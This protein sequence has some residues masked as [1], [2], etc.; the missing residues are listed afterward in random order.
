MIEIDKTQYHKL[1]DDLKDIETVPI[2]ALAIIDNFIEGVVLTD[3]EYHESY[4]IGTNNGIYFVYG[5]P[6]K[7]F[8]DQLQNYYNE[9]Y[10]DRFTI[11]TPSDEWEHIIS[12]I[13]ANQSK[14]MRRKLF[15][16]N[17]RK[18][19]CTV[20]EDSRAI[21]NYK[22]L[23]INKDIIM[24]SDIFN[25]QYYFNNWGS[26]PRFLKNGFGFCAINE[27]N[28]IVSECTNIFRSKSKAEIDIY[29]IEK[30]RG[31]G[32]AYKLASLFINQCLKQKVLPSWDCDLTNK[33]SLYL[34]ERLN[35]DYG[36]EYTIFYK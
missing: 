21:N 33:S 12:E 24:K 29:T 15:T 11:F 22:V 2:F 23:S 6:N 14:T 28:E 13:V 4:L 8:I 30:A 19:L 35:F 5:K 26:L 10:A 31:N 1:S 18:F 20:S 3:S 27:N 34:A 32:L 7:M 9:R 17:Q 36:K 25:Q 16:L